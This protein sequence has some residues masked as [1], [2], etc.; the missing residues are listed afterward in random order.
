MGLSAGAASGT[1]RLAALVALL[2]AATLPPPAPALAAGTKLPACDTAGNP[3]RPLIIRKACLLTLGP[4]DVLARRIVLDGA[5]ASGT[6]ISCRGGLIAPSEPDAAKR[7]A[8]TIRSTPGKGGDWSVPTDIAI[9][10]CRIRG[11]VR[12]QGLGRN[13]E[14]GRVRESSHSEGH[15]QR[16]QAAAPRDVRLSGLDIEATGRVAVYLAPGV[17]NVTLERSRIHGRANGPA[18]Y[19]DAES[20]NNRIVGNEIDGASVRRE[21]IAVDGS[22]G[23]LV[24]GNT[25]TGAKGGIFLYRNCGEGGTVRH[26]T[27]RDNILTDNSISGGS[28]PDIWLGARN[29]APRS[30]CGLDAQFP[31]GSG[32]SDRDFATH[33]RV[34]GNR[35]AQ[36][37]RP[38]RIVD[39]DADNLV[40]QP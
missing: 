15:K 4:Q 5:G 29:L 28:A 19:M 30:Y 26:Q 11:G 25:I 37:G 40:T 22:A 13:G 27:P 24:T 2:A 1:L 14:A 7:D 21:Q 32:A 9:E 12:V 31:F 35:S 17:T 10:G 23:N 39:D 16:A 36:A 8:V 6:R 20:G 33:N 34:S 18:I 38:L 3:G